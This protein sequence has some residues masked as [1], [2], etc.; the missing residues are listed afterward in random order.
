[1]WD[2]ALSF[3]QSDR[4]QTDPRVLRAQLALAARSMR[5]TRY[6]LPLW[7][8]VVAILCSQ[9]TGALGSVPV[10]RAMLLPVSAPF[11][12]RLMQPAA[13]AMDVRAGHQIEG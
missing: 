3:F 4:H 7:A 11:H 13:D 8:L 2:K 5:A 9:L 1:M 6:S 10:L 12:C